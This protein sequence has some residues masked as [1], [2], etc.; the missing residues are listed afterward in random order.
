MVAFSK[1]I[2]QAARLAN[3]VQERYPLPNSFTMYFLDCMVSLLEVEDERE[4]KRFFR[5]CGIDAHVLHVPKS[6]ETTR[7]E[8]QGGD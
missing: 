3:I 1:D 6:E 7:E 4:F 5:M 2:K 8:E